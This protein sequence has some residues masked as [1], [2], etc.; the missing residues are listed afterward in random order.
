MIVAV[1][2]NNGKIAVNKAAL[3]NEIMPENHYYPFGMTFGG[4]V[5]MND[6]ADIDNRYQYNGKE[7]NNDYDA[8]QK[9]DINN[10]KDSI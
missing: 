9:E 7:L 2:N 6:A 3:D 10:N 8:P 5:W 4:N 1:G